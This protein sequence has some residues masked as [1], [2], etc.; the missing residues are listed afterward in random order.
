MSSAD[1]MLKFSEYIS[2]SYFVQYI[3]D[4]NVDVLKLKDSKQASWVEVR[5]KKNYEVTYDK[6]DPLHKAIDGLGKAAS[7]SDLM[8]GDVVSINPHH[9]H[10]KKA[11]ETVERLMK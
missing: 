2:E 10:G 11:I 1:K 8:N 4:K 7:I 3:R 5:G 6:N 9:P